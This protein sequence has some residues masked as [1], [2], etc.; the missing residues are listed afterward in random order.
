VRKTFPGAGPLLASSIVLVSV[1]ADHR[2]AMATL[3]FVCVCMGMCSSNLWA[4]T[5]TLAGV[6][7]AGKWTGV[8]NFFGN[9]AGIVA[10]WLTGLVVQRTGHFF[11]AF[12]IV[13]VV[14]TLGGLSWIFA[15]GPIR[16]VP[17][18]SQS[19]AS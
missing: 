12:V 18:L 15:I 5:Q 7:T 11:W 10:P 19:P 16:P 14:T 13:A 9:F 6:P 17:W 1:I 2:V 3:I 8:Q 4:V